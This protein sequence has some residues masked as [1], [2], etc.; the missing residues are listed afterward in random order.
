MHGKLRLS[1][2]W[3]LGLALILHVDQ[4]GDGRTM[5]CVSLFLP[6]LFFG[7]QH[8]FHG[9][10]P[11]SDKQSMHERMTSWFSLYRN[12]YADMDLTDVSGVKK[13]LEDILG[14]F[15]QSRLGQVRPICSY[16]KLPAN[17]C[18]LPSRTFQRLPIAI[19]N[20]PKVH[21]SFPLWAH[22][23]RFLCTELR[24]SP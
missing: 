20:V 9:Q 1:Q 23:E 13:Q 12:R 15:N 19:P 21:L 18:L 24:N 11:L 22:I 6:H 3:V 5:R 14:H 10:M 7:G 8:Y 16:S 17:A 2:S 4:C